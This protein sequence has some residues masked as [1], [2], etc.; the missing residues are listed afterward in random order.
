MANDSR[1]TMTK[2]PLG[3]SFLASWFDPFQSSSS[4]S[5]PL[6]TNCLQVNETNIKIKRYGLFPV[7]FKLPRLRPWTL[8]SA[9]HTG[10]TFNLTKLVAERASGPSNKLRF[11]GDR[12][13]N[14]FAWLSALSWRLRSTVTAASSLP[15]VMALAKNWLSL[16]LA[17]CHLTDE[18]LDLWSKYGVNMWKRVWL[19]L[20]YLFA[21]RWELQSNLKP[22]VEQVV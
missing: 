1:K 14:N 11:L 4:P 7:L 20:P 22:K 16:G 6:R 8:L 12:A 3:K 2:K 15:I 5:S 18:D 17:Q 13:H 21:L 10:F 9:W 19:L